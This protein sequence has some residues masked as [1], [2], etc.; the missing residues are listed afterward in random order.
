MPNRGV[1]NQLAPRQFITTELAERATAVLTLDDLCLWISD[2]S[3]TEY[4]HSL[5]RQCVLDGPIV[6]IAE[7]LGVEYIHE[8]N[9]LSG[10]GEINIVDARLDIVANRLREVFLVAC[11]TSSAAFISPLRHDVVLQAT[12]LWAFQRISKTLQS[13]PD[14]SQMFCN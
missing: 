5:F 11:S 10:P 1:H 7:C 3:F 14:I 8:V 4:Y 9:A 13:D 12:Y 2:E 6:I